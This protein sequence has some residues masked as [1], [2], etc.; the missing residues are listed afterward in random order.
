MGGIQIIETLSVLAS[1]RFGREEIS[2]PRQRKQIE[3][4]AATV[5]SSLERPPFRP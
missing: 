1:G 3:P 4:A 5:S 2:M